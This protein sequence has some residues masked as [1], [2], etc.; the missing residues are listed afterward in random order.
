MAHPDPASR[1]RTAGTLLLISTILGLLYDLAAALLF[2]AGIFKA[3]DG[4][5]PGSELSRQDV[6]A[7]GTAFFFA[8]VLVNGV[9]I[10]GAYNTMKLRNRHL[11]VVGACAAILPCPSCLMMNFPIGIYALYVLTRPE[12][13]AAFVAASEE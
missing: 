3:P 2:M 6:F 8:G 9:A 10:M 5:A 4:A 13:T 12:T 1:A 11:G 7:L